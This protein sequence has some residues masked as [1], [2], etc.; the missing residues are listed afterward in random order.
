MSRERSRSPRRQEELADRQHWFKQE[1]IVQ[2]RQRINGKVVCADKRMVDL[3]ARHYC[4]Q[5]QEAKGTL[6]GGFPEL[7]KLATLIVDAFQGFKSGIEGVVA[8]LADYENR[9]PA[10]PEADRDWNCGRDRQ[11]APPEGGSSSSIRVKT[12]VLRTIGMTKDDLKNLIVDEGFITQV[13]GTRRSLEVSTTASVNSYAG[14]AI[15][16]G[17]TNAHGVNLRCHFY[18]EGIA[19]DVGRR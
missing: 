14:L 2:F 18:L 15:T 9:I 4:R 16:S 1:I 3:A 5:I 8:V 7:T 10:N 6:T 19:A 13:A 12:G 17:K 11:D